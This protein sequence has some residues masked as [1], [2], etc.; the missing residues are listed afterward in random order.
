MS[1][2]M[3]LSTYWQIYYKACS[4][5]IKFH[6]NQVDKAGAPYYLHPKRV[7]DNI[8][9]MHDFDY[10]SDEDKKFVL[11]C[12]SVAV[13]HDVLEDT[14]CTAEY[15]LEQHFPEDIVEAIKAVTRQNGESYSQFIKRAEQNVYAK[16]VKFYDLQDNLDVTRLQ[17]LTLDDLKRL[18]KYLKWYN[19]LKQ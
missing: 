18:N 19:Y 9:N 11:S 4:L 2:I 5:S 17:E 8:M 3:P 7:A 15:L 12:A 6:K 16:I 14:E 1:Y 13:L 10:I